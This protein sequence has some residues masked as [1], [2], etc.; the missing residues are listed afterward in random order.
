[1]GKIAIRL[2][3]FQQI[4]YLSSQ[5]RIDHTY[6]YGETQ[7]SCF[8]ERRGPFANDYN[9][10]NAACLWHFVI[11]V[12]YTVPFHMFVPPLVRGASRNRNALFLG[13]HS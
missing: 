1:M 3:H 5:I 10:T 6:E 2:P 4:P 11:P 12:E 7:L 8:Y 9:Y 13:R